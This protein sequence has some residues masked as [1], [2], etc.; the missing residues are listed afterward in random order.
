MILL[1]DWT[2]AWM[3]AGIGVGIV[4]VILIL[5]VFVLQVF[6][7]MARKTTAK[8]R[9]VKADYNAQKQIK[10]FEESSDRDKAAVAM[11]LY[12]YFN[13]AHDRESGVLTLKQSEIPS[14]WHA[15]LND[16]Y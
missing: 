11:A 12:L 15:V 6:S 4:Y 5:L 10:A 7:V 16:K 1:T 9:A 14:L 13:G 8:T 2:S 3:M